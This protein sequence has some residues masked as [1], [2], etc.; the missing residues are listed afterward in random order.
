MTFFFPRPTI[1][2]PKKASRNKAQRQKVRELNELEKLGIFT[3]G[4]LKKLQESLSQSAKHREVKDKEKAS[5]ESGRAE[6][7]LWGDNAGMLT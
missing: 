7:D 4:R 3:D 2:N 5:R 6:Y 1:Y